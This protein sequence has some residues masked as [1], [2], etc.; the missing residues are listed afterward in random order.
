MTEIG[1]TLV[2]KFLGVNQ[3]LTEY[4]LLIKLN[5]LFRLVNVSGCARVCHTSFVSCSHL[6]L[7][8][9]ELLTFPLFVE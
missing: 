2:S 7:C 6:T 3:N 1:D 4:F 9:S 5:I 8:Y